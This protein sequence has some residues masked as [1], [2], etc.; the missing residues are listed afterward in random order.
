ME[1]PLHFPEFVS[2]AY[3]DSAQRPS[4]NFLDQIFA[5]SQY[6]EGHL[7]VFTGITTA[8]SFRFFLNE[9]NQPAFQFKTNSSSEIWKGGINDLGIILFRSLPTNT[10]SFLQPS[11]ITTDIRKF[12][13]V[14]LSRHISNSGFQYFQQLQ[15]NCF[16]PLTIQN[17]IT[18]LQFPSSLTSVDNNNPTNSLAF[19]GLHDEEAEISF[20]EVQQEFMIHSLQK[21]HIGQLIL[22]NVQVGSFPFGLFRVQSIQ[23][24]TFSAIPLLPFG[25][26]LDATWLEAPTM[27][28]TLNKASIMFTNLEL[29]KTQSL[30]KHWIQ[31]LKQLQQ[32]K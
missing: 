31:K 25:E 14:L 3:R 21:N 20:N 11:Q 8:R 5:I 27:K 22:C 29:T 18:W 12:L 17:P 7:N 30:K 24:K 23:K 1:T 6:F 15:S 16:F 2:R 32:L 26:N 13:Q 9:H 19:L 10:C 28:K 4:V